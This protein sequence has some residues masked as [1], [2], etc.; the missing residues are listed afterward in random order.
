MF[1]LIFCVLCVPII[2]LIGGWCMRYHTPKKINSWIG[3]RTTNAMKNADTWKLANQYCGKLWLMIGTVSLILSA[4]IGFSCLFFS[5][6]IVKSSAT[7]SEKKILK[8]L[9]GSQKIKTFARTIVDEI[10]NVL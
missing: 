6:Q 8:H 7:Q 9:E 3:Y 1:F 2:Q 5:R 10:D 4:I